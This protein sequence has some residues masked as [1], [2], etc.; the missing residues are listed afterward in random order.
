MRVVRQFVYARGGIARHELERVRRLRQRDSLGPCLDPAPEHLRLVLASRRFHV[1]AAGGGADLAE[2]RRLCLRIRQ[3]VEARVDVDA[4]DDLVVVQLHIGIPAVDQLREMRKRQT[5]QRDPRMHLAAAVLCADVG[6]HVIEFHAVL[7]ALEHEFRGELLAVLAPGGAC[8][9]RRRQVL[10]EMRDAP[11]EFRRL[12]LRQ[13]EVRHGLEQRLRQRH[14]RIDGTGQERIARR[15]DFHG[16][17]VGGGCDL[18]VALGGRQQRRR[19][20]RNVEHLAEVGRGHCSRL[21]R[22]PIAAVSLPGDRRLEHHHLR[23]GRVVVVKAVLASTGEYHKQE[24]GNVQHDGQEPRHDT[25]SDRPFETL[26]VRQR[27]APGAQRLRQHKVL[28]WKSDAPAS[29]PICGHPFLTSQ[30]GGAAN[31]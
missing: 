28:H 22:W 12:R 24:Q 29:A 18:R 8:A 17:F 15:D 27:S 3:H 23:H 4:A 31:R 11:Q 9:R 25:W 13:H 10:G 19:D 2:Q 16:W 30:C 14:H 6:D 21:L 7:R 1:E 5:L 20:L 26:Q